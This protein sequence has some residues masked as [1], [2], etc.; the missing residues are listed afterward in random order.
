M[1]H[2]NYSQCQL[3]LLLNITQQSTI[4]SAFAAQECDMQIQSVSIF[5]WISIIWR[6]Q[7]GE[8]L[9]FAVCELMYHQLSTDNFEYILLVPLFIY[10]DSE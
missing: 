10:W 5:F 3:V 6:L 2:L 8:K 1:H 4:L 9:L 7:M